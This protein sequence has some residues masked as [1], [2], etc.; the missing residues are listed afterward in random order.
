MTALRR[1]IGLVDQPDLR[2][3]P[4]PAPGL[5]AERLQGKTA[6]A[7]ALMQLGDAPA[8]VCAKNGDGKVG[9]RVDRVGGRLAA[10]GRN[11]RSAAAAPSRRRPTSSPPN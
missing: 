10:R 4:L 11:A 1:M 7:R 6:E 3:G 5:H 8:H 2:P 9:A